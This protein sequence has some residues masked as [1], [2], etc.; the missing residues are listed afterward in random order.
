MN[1]QFSKV[2]YIADYN[3]WT[4]PNSA[5]EWQQSVTTGSELLQ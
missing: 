2:E 4:A 1:K 3:L 5:M